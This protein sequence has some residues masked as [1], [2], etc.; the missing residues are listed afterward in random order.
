MSHGHI[1]EIES[2]LSV[3]VKSDPMSLSSRFF[4]KRLAFGVR[5]PPNWTIDTT[6][7][8]TVVRAP[9][10]ASTGCTLPMCSLP[11]HGRILH[12]SEDKV[13]PLG[14][15]SFPDLVNISNGYKVNPARS[16]SEWP[17]AA[18]APLR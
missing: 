1:S 14:N 17:P 16:W 11:S 7:R 4:W 6:V 13:A 3:W 8:A 12:A 9:K 5:K 10:F 15:T 18:A 2:P